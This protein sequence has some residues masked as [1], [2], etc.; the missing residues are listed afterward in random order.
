M[1]GADRCISNQIDG[2]WARMCGSFA[3]S[4]LP[5]ALRRPDTTQLFDPCPDGNGGACRNNSRAVWRRLPPSLPGRT[6]AG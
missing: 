3:S 1:P 2:F 4:G 5:V 6:M